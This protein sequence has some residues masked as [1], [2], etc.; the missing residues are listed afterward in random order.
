MYTFK[1]KLFGLEVDVSGMFDA[2][3]QQTMTDPAIPPCFEIEEIVH[4]DELLEDL[5]D[6]AYEKLEQAAFN[7]ATEEAQECE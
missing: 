1:T 2:G 5:P 6:E 3:Q 7:A 4:K